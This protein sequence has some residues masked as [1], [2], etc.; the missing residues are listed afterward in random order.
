MKPT[1]AKVPRFL[2]AA[3]A[4]S[5]ASFWFYSMFLPTYYRLVVGIAATCLQIAPAGPQI[6]FGSDGLGGR[7]RSLVRW[8]SPRLYSWMSKAMRLDAVA[9]SIDA[10]GRSCPGSDGVVREVLHGPSL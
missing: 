10:L 5:I 8:L 2:A 4:L 7:R 6:R 1:S 3:L 9:A